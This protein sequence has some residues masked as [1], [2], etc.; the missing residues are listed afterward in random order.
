[1]GMDVLCGWGTLPLPG[2]VKPKPVKAL[3]EVTVRHVRHKFVGEVV[4]EAFM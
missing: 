1:M 3:M 2:I 4:E